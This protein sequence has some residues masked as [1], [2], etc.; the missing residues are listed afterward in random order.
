VEDNLLLF[1]EKF[2]RVSGILKG[3]HEESKQNEIVDIILTES[4]KKSEIEGEYPNR[5]D[6]LSSIRKNLGLYHIPEQIKDKSVKKIDEIG[7]KNK[8]IFNR[9]TQE[10]NPVMKLSNSFFFIN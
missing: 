10:G 5:K 9:K 8:S 4:I 3:L 1:S 7:N 2:G 6:V